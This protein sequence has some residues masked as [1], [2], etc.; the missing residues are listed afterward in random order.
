VYLL[1]DPDDNVYMMQSYTTMVNPNITIDTLP[2]LVCML[3][4]DLDPIWVFKN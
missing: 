4:S 1:T 3:G 2:E